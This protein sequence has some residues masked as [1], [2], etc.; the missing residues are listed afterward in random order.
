MKLLTNC[1]SSSMKCF[2]LLLLIY[3]PLWSCGG[4]PV[5]AYGKGGLTAADL[6][7]V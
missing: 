2:L 1:M 5:D 7:D 4:P 3:P 6:E